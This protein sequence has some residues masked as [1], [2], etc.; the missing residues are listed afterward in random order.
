MSLDLVDR[1]PHYDLGGKSGHG[2]DGG[3]KNL[4]LHITHMMVL[5]NSVRYLKHYLARLRAARIR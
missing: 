5:H 2:G 4:Q 3:I 1:L